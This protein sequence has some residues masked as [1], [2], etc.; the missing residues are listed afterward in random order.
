MKR[1]RWYRC[2]LLGVLCFC[3]LTG[4]GMPLLAQPSNGN[5]D[6]EGRPD[7][8]GILS[9]DACTAA[10]GIWQEGRGQMMRKDGAR[11]ENGNRVRG[12]CAEKKCD[13]ITDFGWGAAGVGGT[14]ALLSGA[15]SFIPPLAPAGVLLVTIGGAGVLGASLAW[16]ASDC[17]G[18]GDRRDY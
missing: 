3:L 12:S 16:F 15:G 6:R 9:E 5:A 8:S 14:G 11:D 2:P 13:E 17:Q 10:G 4:G 1:D 7:F 18:G